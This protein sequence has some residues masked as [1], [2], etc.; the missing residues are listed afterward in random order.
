VT[1][2]SVTWVNRTR[3]DSATR[4]GRR[5]PHRGGLVDEVSTHPPVPSA[6]GED[7]ADEFAFGDAQQDRCTVTTDG[8]TGP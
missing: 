7:E 4:P 5:T 8:L 3:T 1:R 2:W 6:L